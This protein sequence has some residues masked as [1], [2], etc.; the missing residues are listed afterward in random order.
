M[1]PQGTISS[2]SG[3][4]LQPQHQQVPVSIPSWHYVYVRVQ[5]TLTIVW[6]QLVTYTN[7]MLPRR[8]LLLLMKM[9][10]TVGG[11][12]STYKMARDDH[13]VKQLPRVSPEKGAYC[14]CV[15]KVQETEMGL[16]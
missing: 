6:M 15:G 1:E 4:L 12:C 13:A 8:M 14:C 9:R 5:C 7:R 3:Q 2:K 16:Q 11:E 10:S